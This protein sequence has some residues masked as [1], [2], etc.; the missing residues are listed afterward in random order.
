MKENNVGSNWKSRGK[1]IAIIVSGFFILGG[2]AY[3]VTYH[4]GTQAKIEESVVSIYN[5]IETSFVG[6]Y[7]KIEDAAVS[8]Y[9]KV[10]DTFVG[11]RANQ[12]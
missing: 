12:E 10:E 2:V 9:Q 3:G 11:D 5:S 6:G 8:G 4:N 1:R 7:Q